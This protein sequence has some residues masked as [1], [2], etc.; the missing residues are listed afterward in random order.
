MHKIK[1]MNNKYYKKQGDNIN[2]EDTEIVEKKDLYDGFNYD[3]RKKTSSKYYDFLK[4]SFHNIK[5]F[6]KI[7]RLLNIVFIYT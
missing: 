2:D 7:K 5:S 1:E 3:R 4:I 6:N